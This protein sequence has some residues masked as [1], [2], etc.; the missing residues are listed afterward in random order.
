MKSTSQG[1]WSDGTNGEG[2]K[3]Q[4][5]T[6]REGDQKLTTKKRGNPLEER[7]LSEGKAHPETWTPL[8]KSKSK[9]DRQTFRPRFR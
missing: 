8:L 1:P 3:V 5:R 6:W 9:Q 2:W 4:C 7:A